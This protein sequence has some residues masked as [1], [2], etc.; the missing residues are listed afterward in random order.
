MRRAATTRVRLSVPVATAKK[1][2]P[3]VVIYPVDFQDAGHIVDDV[4]TVG[5]ILPFEPYIMGLDQ[6]MHD[7]MV[8]DTV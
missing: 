8:C 5:A 2:I 6:D 1:L 4:S 3:Y 7:I